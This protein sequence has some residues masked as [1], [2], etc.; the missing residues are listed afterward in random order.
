M[1]FQAV[2]RMGFKSPMRIQAYAWP[3]ILR[4]CSTVMV[5]PPHS[6]KTLGYVIPIVS[7]M[8]EQDLFSEVSE[9]FEPK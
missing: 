4:G 8:L 7:F 5:S 9:L 1:F 6:G 2:A 3:V